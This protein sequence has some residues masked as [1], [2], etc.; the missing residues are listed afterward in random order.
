MPQPR[1]YVPPVHA[2]REQLSRTKQA[3]IAQQSAIEQRIRSRSQYTHGR[4]RRTATRLLAA[5]AVIARQ[6]TS[7]AGKA[8]AR[9]PG[10]NLSMP[11]RDRTAAI[12]CALDPDARDNSGP[13]RPSM[14]PAWMPAAPTPRMAVTSTLRH[15][16]A[17]PLRT[18]QGLHAITGAVLRIPTLADAVGDLHA[19][20][21]GLRADLSG[22]PADS[23]RLADDVEIVHG[24]LAGMN[25][26]L[27]D[28][29]ASAAPVHD[30]LARVEAGLAP[31][32]NQLDRLLP[33]IDELDRRLDEMRV[34]LTEQLN[35][36]RTDLSGLPFVSKSS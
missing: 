22:M 10:L 23:R 30:D 20:L 4:A 27:A 21:A 9:A 24:V 17:L 32:P 33:K 14:P 11:L 25:A 8:A 12:A 16:I 13:A 6:G 26:D 2:V 7:I 29:K 34:E 1:R 35:G 28:V 19:E 36:L 31:L 18:A 15:A 5:H 3:D